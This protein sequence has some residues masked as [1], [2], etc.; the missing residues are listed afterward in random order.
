M[1]ICPTCK[2]ET[3]KGHA[4]VP[5]SDKDHKCEWCGSLVLEHRHLCKEKIKDLSYICNS[6]GRA[7][8]DPS[9]LC[10]PKKV[11]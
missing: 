7:A 4:C 10:D 2:K 8:V 3:E 5:L 9:L 11:E 6:C 1:S